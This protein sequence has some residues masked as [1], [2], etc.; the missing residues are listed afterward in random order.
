MMTMYS[1]PSG[2]Y[3]ELGTNGITFVACTPATVVDVCWGRINGSVLV[4]LYDRLWV[5]DGID[6]TTG[7]PFT[8]RIL[9]RIRDSSSFMAVLSA[10]DCIE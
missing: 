7:K 4:G 1:P 9:D 2:S 5:C 6:P 8:Q 3:L 10:V